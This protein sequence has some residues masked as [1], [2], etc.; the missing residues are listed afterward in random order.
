MGSY[1]FAGMVGFT[2]GYGLRM[3]TP[4]TPGDWLWYAI[5]IP[6]IISAMVIYDEWLVAKGE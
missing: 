6:I 1:L 4:F 3:F 2:L 5:C